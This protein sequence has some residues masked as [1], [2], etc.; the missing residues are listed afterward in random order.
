MTTQESSRS[1]R[2]NMRISPESHE[3]LRSAAAMQQQDVSSF[4]LG[5]ALERARAIVIE[6]QVIRLSPHAVMLL[7]K[8]LA[9]DAKIVP[10]LAELFRQ[11]NGSEV[12]S[13]DSETVDS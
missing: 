4:V 3:L 10:Q 9:S 12:Q 6:N 13:T 5:A 11:M 8:E 2:L 7:E 1:S